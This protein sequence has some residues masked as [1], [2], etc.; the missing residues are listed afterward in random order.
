IIRKGKIT[1]IYDKGTGAVVHSLRE[2]YNE[3]GERLFDVTWVHFY[4]DAG[5][6]GGDPGPKTKKINPPIDKEPNFRISY[7]IAEN[8]AAIYRLSGDLNP[9]HLDPVF[10]SRSGRFK[11]P[12]LHGLCTYGFATRAI[13]YGACNGE[14]SRFKE[15]NARF[16]SPVYPG[17]TLTTEGWKEKDRYIIQART[18]RGIVLKNSYAVV[19]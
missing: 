1:H 7:K 14:I 10:A 16:S 12:I 18:E 4:L 9:L 5:G 13:L 3:K 17:E 2:G 8:Q 15:F 11:A 19:G 6:F